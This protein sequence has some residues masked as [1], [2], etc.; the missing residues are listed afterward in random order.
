MNFMIS[1]NEI[2]K[3]AEMSRI[4]LNEGEKT[5]LQK[6]I[7][8]ILEYVTQ[9]QS[10]AVGESGTQSSTSTSMGAQSVRNVMRPDT[11]AKKG[12]ECTA[13]IMANVPKKTDNFVQVKKIIS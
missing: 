9:I 8:E 13:D 3:L 12:G 1:L 6:E 5:T 2:E 7:G 10:V 11:T 4:S